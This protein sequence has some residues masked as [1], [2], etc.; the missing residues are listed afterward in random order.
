MSVS[1]VI[2][3]WNGRKLLERNLSK[4]IEASENPDNKVLEVIVVD[5]ASTDDSVSYL[6]ANFPKVK[7]I[8]HKKNLGF[9]AACNTGVNE[10]K[11][12]LVAILNL[13]VV[14]AKDFLKASLP[15]FRDQKTFAVTFNEGKFGSGRLVWKEG[16]LQILPSVFSKTVLGTD[17]ASGG[18]SV[19]R[20]KLWQELG[21]MDRLFLPFYYEDIDLSLRASRK[22]YRCFWEPKSMVVHQHEATINVNNFRQGYLD[23]IKQ[24]NHLLL[25]WKNIASWQRFLSHLFYLGKKSFSH[26]GYLKIVFKSLVRLIISLWSSQKGFW[27]LLFLALLIRLAVAPVWHHSDADSIYYWSKYLWEKKTFLNFL[28]NPIPG[29]SP[30]PYPPIFYLLLFWWRGFYDLVGRFL[31]FLNLKIP[32][33]PS[34]LIF[35]YQGR[36]AGVAFNKLPAIMADFGCAFLIYRIGRI[37]GGKKNLVKVSAWLFLL[38][39][40]T[41]YNSAYWGQTESL[42]SVFVLLSFYFALRDKFLLGLFSL[43]ISALVKSTGVIVFPVF[44]VLAL[45]RKKFV[46]LLGGAILSVFTAFLLYYPFRPI[47]TLPWA[48]KF[49]LN[50]FH[51]E[52]NYIVSNAFNLWAFI[53]GFEPRL[54]ESLFLGAPLSYIGIF[55][56]SIF[57]LIIIIKL[58][59]S[60]TSR[61]FI[62]AAFLSSF[63]A[64]LF[65]PRMHERYFYTALVFSAVLA[66]LRKKW[67][68]LF[69]F[70]SL[71]HFINLYHFWRYPKIPLLISVFSNLSVVRLIILSTMVVFF[72]FLNDFLKDETINNNR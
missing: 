17:W 69:V 6:K 1:V 46:D 34:N 28:G 2:A 66:G 4:V 44:L 20:K 31:W 71:V 23:D 42:Y 52:L 21:G 39:P 47:N 64:F 48:I 29:A 30:P 19:F 15:H 14:P 37:I 43:T 35:W 65:L 63:A 26:P 38:L 49:Y 3:C 27:L 67:L 13:D 5:D 10:A 58:W 11:G 25:T 60:N 56:F 53:F 54:A 7:I 62:F 68:S 72:L 55:V 40:V 41:W 61:K 24:R 22:G 18:S 59:K 16:F 9:A 32:L 57:F 12:D 33:F 36:Y 50:S 70:L 45:R 8:E 51:G